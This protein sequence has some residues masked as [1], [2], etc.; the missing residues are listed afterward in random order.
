MNI[1]L[2][3]A[4]VRVTSMMMGS[5]IPPLCC[6]LYCA[7]YSGEPHSCWSWLI[8]RQSVKKYVLTVSHAVPNNLRLHLQ[9]LLR[10][11]IQVDSLHLL[12]NSLI[13]C[14]SLLFAGSVLSLSHTS[15]AGAH[16][17]HLLLNKGSKAMSVATH[18][19][20]WKS[21]EATTHLL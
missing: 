3:V 19:G 12:C 20:Y 10:W 8:S 9:W 7:L 17:I 11:N 6:I 4:V 2:R 1:Y 18:Q 14:V 15:C 21:S 16:I 13:I 5:T